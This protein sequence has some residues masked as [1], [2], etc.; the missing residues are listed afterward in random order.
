MATKVILAGILLLHAAIHLLFL[1]PHPAT[2]AGGTAWAFEI[3]RSWALS[4]LGA[5]SDVLR[6]VAIALMAVIV[7]GY[8]LAVLSMFRIT[9]GTLWAPAIAVGS[10]GSIA[11]LGLFFHRYLAL[12]VGIDLVLLWAVL[13]ARW[14]PE[15]V[16]R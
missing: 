16:R 14:A 9:P 1:S 12:G 15:G 5:G 13:F 8:A 6:M 3:G 11:L 10:F 4:P 2:A 7:L